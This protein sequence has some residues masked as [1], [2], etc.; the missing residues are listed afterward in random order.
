MTY[1]RLWRPGEQELDI[2]VRPR[3]V[4][5]R[6]VLHSWRPAACFVHLSD[7]EVTPILPQPR[8]FHHVACW[9]SGIGVQSTVNAPGA[10]TVK[11]LSFASARLEPKR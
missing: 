2:A 9:D 4:V 7:A 1:Q 5:A 3:L 10:C 8:F 6:A 11:K